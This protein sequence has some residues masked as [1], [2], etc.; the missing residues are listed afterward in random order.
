[1]FNELT[2]SQMLR[3]PDHYAHEIRCTKQGNQHRATNA[4][5]CPKMWQVLLALGKINKCAS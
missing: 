2:V 5:M 1:M 3:T 4:K